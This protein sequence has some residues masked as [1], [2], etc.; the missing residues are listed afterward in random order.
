MNEQEKACVQQRVQ[1]LYRY[2][3]AM[4]H[5]E[6]EAIATVLEQ[7]QQD[8]TLARMV[9]ELNEVYQIEDRSVVHADDVALAHEMLLDVFAQSTGNTDE[10]EMH[11]SD[12]EALPRLINL[13]A[14]ARAN[15]RPPARKWRQSRMA[16][17]VAAILL[18]ILIVPALSA[19]A[20]QF[21]ALFSPQQ[22]VG[23]SSNTFQNPNLV[24]NTLDSF[25]QEIG[26][27]TILDY[28]GQRLATPILDQ[29]LA[30]A[31][32]HFHIQLPAILADGAGTTPQF[33]VTPGEQQQFTFEA[34]KARG[35]LQS[36]QQT[37]IALPAQLDGATFKITLNSGVLVTYYQHC[38][39]TGTTPTCSGGTPFGV[40]EIPNPTLQAENGASLSDL[41]SFLL[42]L[43]KLPASIHTLL[44]NVDLTSGV[45]PIPLPKG[46][47]SAQTTVKG[48][49]ALL[50][51]SSGGGGIIWESQNIVYILLTTQASGSQLQAMAN[52]LH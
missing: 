17:L 18:A 30:E 43:P 3:D 15:R 38:K 48:V 8:A 22:F 9:L 14:Q 16:A 35:Y 33:S 26:T 44:Q 21:L 36:T 40:T 51:T 52:S 28:N 12:A 42:S 50:V 47:S 25:L 1:A 5:G 23:V 37:N 6:V 39:L 41:R 10:L 19:F 2:T 13:P 29:R 11:T 7:A 24:M 31:K 45:V 27:N 34:A 20:P 49:R 46:V 32:I 4:E